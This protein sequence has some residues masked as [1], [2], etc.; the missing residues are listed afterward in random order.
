MNPEDL[1]EAVV[2]TMIAVVLGVIAV[3]I[4]NPNLG[5]ALTGLLPQFIQLMVWVLVA[6]VIASLLFRIVQQ[7]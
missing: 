5:S 2:T 7:L 3:T 1:V 6:A 4:W